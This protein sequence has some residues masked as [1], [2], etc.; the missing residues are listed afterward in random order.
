MLAIGAAIWLLIA[1]VIL[2][3]FW[4]HM[5]RSTAQWALFIAFG[6]PLYVLAEGFFEWVFSGTRK[7]SDG[8]RLGIL[9]VVGAIY[10]GFV[11][12]FSA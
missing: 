7:L 2:L 6:P 5:P 10:V 12:V 4:P 1:G 8:A 9:L 11:A 3:N